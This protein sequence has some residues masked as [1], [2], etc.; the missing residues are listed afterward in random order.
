MPIALTPEHEALADAVRQFAARH[1]PVDTTRPALDALAAGQMP[2]WWQ[3]LV[4]NGFHAVH[5]AEDVGGQGGDLVDTGC[6]IEAA[7]HA[8]LPG[9]LLSTAAAGAVAL[10]ADPV[11]A[12]TMLLGEPAA[13]ATAVVVPADTAN[14]R[15]VADGDG[16]VVTGVSAPVLGLRSATRVLVA[17]A[18]DT[19]VL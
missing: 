14:A 1:A 9:P 2:S 6:V 13:G 18:T 12:V 7:A 3:D 10:L 4:A 11:P 5:L 8:L 15:A 19:D 16:W 17:A